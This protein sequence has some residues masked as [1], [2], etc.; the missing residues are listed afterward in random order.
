MTP[1]SPISRD[2]Q[3]FLRLLNQH[4]VKYAI[5]GGHAVAYHGYSRLTMDVDIL[6]LP[7]EENAQ[8]LGQ[9]LADFGFGNAGIPI[10]A[11]TKEG[12]AVSLGVQPNQIDLLTS[13]SSQP[14]AEVIHNSEPATLAGIPVY[15]TAKADLIRAKRESGRPKDLTDLGELQ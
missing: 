4:Q 8:R 6:I 1:A 7:S 10:S 15:V 12:T 9:A 3:D 5:C 11:F 2:M 13:M 14:T